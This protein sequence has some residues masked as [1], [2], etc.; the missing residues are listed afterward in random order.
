MFWALSN[1]VTLGVTTN[2]AFLRQVMLNEAFQL[3]DVTTHFIETHLGEW[4]P[5]VE[6]IPDDVLIA[7]AL[8]EALKSGIAQTATTETAIDDP[9]SPWKQAGRWRIGG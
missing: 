1:F 5:E 9:H 6:H 7:A 2:V 3:G 4:N 8:D